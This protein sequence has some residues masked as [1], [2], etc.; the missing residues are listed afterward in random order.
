VQQSP[1]KPSFWRY[2]ESDSTIGIMQ[3]GCLRL[4]Q[5]KPALKQPNLNM[6]GAAE[7]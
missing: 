2:T 5:A 1:E 6:L 7:T 3:E 4:C